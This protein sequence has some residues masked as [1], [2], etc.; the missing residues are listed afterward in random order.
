MDISV[1]PDGRVYIRWHDGGLFVTVDSDGT[2]GTSCLPGRQEWV[3]YE[4]A[5][6]DDRGDYDDGFEAAIEEAQHAV[7]DIARSRRKARPAPPT[8]P[9]AAKATA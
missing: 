1:D 3:E 4:E 7:G 9:N 6:A 8:N 5:A 2:T